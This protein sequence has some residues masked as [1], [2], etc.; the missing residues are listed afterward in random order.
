MF[1]TSLTSLTSL[2]LYDTHVTDADLFQIS[3]LKILSSLDL[4]WT[5]ITDMGL[6]YLSSHL[7]AYLMLASLNLSFTEEKQLMIYKTLRYYND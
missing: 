6:F 2:N 5:N 4:G 3:T 7:L 1:H